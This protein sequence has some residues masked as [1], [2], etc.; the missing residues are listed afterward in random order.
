MPHDSSGPL[1][2]HPI[3]FPKE[4]LQWAYVQLVLKLEYVYYKA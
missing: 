4:R 3:C 2:R 1:V